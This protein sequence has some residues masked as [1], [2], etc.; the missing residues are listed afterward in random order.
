MLTPFN[1]LLFYIFAFGSSA[2]ILGFI[3]EN[4][5]RRTFFAFI[6]TSVGLAIPSLIAGWRGCGTDTIEYLRAYRWITDTDWDKLFESRTLFDESGHLFLTK[7]LT[8]SEHIRLYFLVYGFLTVYP[9]YLVSLKF[10]KTNIALV[11][12]VFYLGFF[13]TSLNIMRQYLALSLVVFSLPFVFEKRFKP[14]ILCVLLASMFHLSALISIPI[15]FLWTK[16]GRVTPPLILIVILF[17]IFLISI[18]IDKV[19]ESSFFTDSDTAILNRY[20]NYTELDGA[21]NR[22]F[23]LNLFVM[24][25]ILFASKQL[26]EVDNRNALFITMYV[27]SVILGLSGFISPYAKRISYYYSISEIWLVPC[28]P[29]VFTSRRT[30]WTTRV[31]VVIYAVARFTIV[32]YVLDNS[33]LIPY[34]WILPRWSRF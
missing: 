3:N 16:K 9:V 11:M 20:S 14:F 24:I 17:A 28:L 33:G 18:N 29:K 23:Y 32:A 5:R 22:D 4:Q 34:Y 10:N 13:V 30:I 15:Y 21:K 6:I 31:L 8:Y 27:I 7:L 12:F 2:Y 19:L 25:I 26:I 1:S